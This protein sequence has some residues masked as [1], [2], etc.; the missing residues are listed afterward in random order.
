MERIIPHQ[1]IVCRHMFPT[2]VD[3]VAA[4]RTQRALIEMGHIPD[5]IISEI[6]KGLGVSESTELKIINTWNDLVIEAV[7]MI[8]NMKN[9]AYIASRYFEPR[10]SRAGLEAAARGCKINIIHSARAD[11]STSKE[12]AEIMARNPETEAIFKRV[13]ANRNIELKEAGVP[14][15]F[16]VVDSS[17]VAVEIM[18][19]EDAKNFFFGVELESAGLAM[20]LCDYFKELEQNAIR[21]RRHSLLG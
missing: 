21:D 10:I 8:G 20:R 17:T 1:S 3:I 18:N 6:R 15:S 2:L 5:D 11:M 13:L 4:R 7:R 16:V 12:I 9:I 14:F 19:P